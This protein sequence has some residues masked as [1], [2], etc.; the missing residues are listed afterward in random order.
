MTLPPN[1][2][3]RSM[4]EKIADS[5]SVVYVYPICVAYLICPFCW[6]P[7]PQ[8]RKGHQLNKG[9]IINMFEQADQPSPLK[10]SAGRAFHK[11][12]RQNDNEERERGRGRKTERA[13]REVRM[14]SGERMKG[15]DRERG[16]KR[17]EN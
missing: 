13:G 15:T 6:V 5:G 9:L 4:G 1:N 10:L 11:T 3:T 16:G 2:H 7:K 8:W 12:T 14:E 17:R